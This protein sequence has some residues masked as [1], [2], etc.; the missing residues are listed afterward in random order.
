ME[1]HKVVKVISHVAF[2]PLSLQ[3]S[4]RFDMTD[5]LVHQ[6]SVHKSGGWKF[7]FSHCKTS[8]LAPP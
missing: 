3:H 8:V 6:S 2:H 7:G 5:S 4:H 1:K